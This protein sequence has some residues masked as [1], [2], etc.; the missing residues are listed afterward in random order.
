MVHLNC[1]RLVVNGIIYDLWSACGYDPNSRRERDKKKRGDPVPTKDR[2]RRFPFNFTG[3]LAHVEITE[4]QSNGQIS[5]I[6]GYLIHNEGCKISF[7]KQLPAVPL[8]DHVYEVALDQLEKGARWVNKFIPLLLVFPDLAYNSITA[9]QRLNREIL[10][11]QA[12]RG[13]NSFDKKTANI[14]YQ[15]LPSD[16]ATLYRK[17]SCKNRVDMHQRPEY[18]VHDWMDPLSPNFQQEISNA[19]FH[20]SAW[21]EL[22]ERFKVCILT[23][24]MNDAA[25]NYAHHSQLVLDG[26]FGIC[27]SRLLLFIALA[28]DENRKGVPITFFLFLAPTGNKATHAGYNTNIL[29]ELLSHWHNYLN[30]LKPLKGSFTPYVAITDTDTKERGALIQVWPEIVLLLC[31]FHLCQCWTNHRKTAL[32]SKNSDFWQDCVRNRLQALEVQ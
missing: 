28:Q 27:T 22:N 19:I 30:H 13:M 12:Y 29:K 11:K 3:C 1:C 25:W 23:K 10:E 4:L 5:R 9:I 15:F 7:L 18:N 6:A 24:E 26:T 32:W 21:T 2:E 16:N 20:Y 14:R 31:K 17:F 8:H